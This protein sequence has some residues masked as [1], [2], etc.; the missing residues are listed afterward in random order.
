MSSETTL[1][2]SPQSVGTD[3]IPREPS[4]YVRTT[5]YRERTEEA[6]R[7]ITDA[8]AERV[9]RNGEMR[10]LGGPRW[11]FVLDK[12]GYEIRVVCGLKDELKPAVITGYCH[13]EELNGAVS[14]F[15]ERAAHAE[16]IRHVIL[17]SGEWDLLVDI[18]VTEPVPVKEHAVTTPYGDDAAHCQNCGREFHMWATFES[19]HCG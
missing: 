11:A 10:A 6:T 1:G 18:D 4:V 17:R 15:G 8:H 14:E 16:L 7:G 2:E 12:D 5:H 13:V 9:I 19:P 3:W